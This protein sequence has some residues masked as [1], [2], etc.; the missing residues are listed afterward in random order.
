MESKRRLVLKHTSGLY[1]SM[2]AERTKRLF[3]AKR[4]VDEAT[5]RLWLDVSIYAP[6]QPEEYTLVEIIQTVE[7]VNHE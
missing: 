4:F 1:W 7:E 2:T 5:A 3:D 6:E